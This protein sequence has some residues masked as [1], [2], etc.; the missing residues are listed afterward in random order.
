MFFDAEIFELL[1]PLLSDFRLFFGAFG[2]SKITLKSFST[3]SSEKRKNIK[4]CHRVASK[5]RFAGSEVDAKMTLRSMLRHEKNTC[6]ANRRKS[7]IFDWFLLNFGTILGAKIDAKSHQKISR[8]S[9]PQK[10]DQ[11]RPQKCSG[12]LWAD[13]FLAPG[14]PGKGG[15]M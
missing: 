4:K 3:R 8:K 12:D 10:I 11:K 7:Q 9:I 6:N 13:Y 15:G 14:L 2:R 1:G 5:S